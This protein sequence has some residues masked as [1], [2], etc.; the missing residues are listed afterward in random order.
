M[1]C[2]GSGF[3]G[4]AETDFKKASIRISLFSQ[5]STLWLV[6]TD[7]G[8]RS[9]ETSLGSLRPHVSSQGPLA[10][11]NVQDFGRALTEGQW[12]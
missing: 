5:T 10:A 1:N 2:K 11:T 4:D 7:S 6:L 12:S 3:Q 9:P 8:H